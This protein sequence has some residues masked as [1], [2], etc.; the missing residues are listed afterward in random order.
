M[1]KLADAKPYFAHSANPAGHW[2]LLKNHLAAVA[3][4]AEAHAGIARWADEA[5]L[6]GLLHDLG[7]YADRL[8]GRLEEKHFGLD[9]WSHAAEAQALALGSLRHYSAKKFL[10]TSS[11]SREIRL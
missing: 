1:N 6:A 8:Q 5:A 7:K 2:H 10:H 3:K 9:R 4:L 11:Q